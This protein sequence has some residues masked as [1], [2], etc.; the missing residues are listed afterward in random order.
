MSTDT[1]TPAAV[2]VVTEYWQ[3]ELSTDAVSHMG[4]QLTGQTG[5]LANAVRN[6]IEEWSIDELSSD[7]I[8]I[9]REQLEAENPSLVGSWPGWDDQ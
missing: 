6:M 5:A 3:D 2:Q 8:A 7:A 9:L 4:D 1:L